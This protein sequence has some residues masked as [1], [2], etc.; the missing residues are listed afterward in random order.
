MV[1][2]AIQ[3]N[4]QI[5]PHA[6]VAF[7]YSKKICNAYIT[8]LT[9]ITIITIQISVTSALITVLLVKLLIL[10]SLLAINVNKASEWTKLAMKHVLYVQKDA[11][12]VN[13]QTISPL[14]S[15]VRAIT[16]FSKV[17]A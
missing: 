17:S 9:V 14:V 13:I 5:V 16:F 7:I 1:V 8:V 11:I 4:K 6:P 2:H 10:Q 12:S 3:Y 15:H